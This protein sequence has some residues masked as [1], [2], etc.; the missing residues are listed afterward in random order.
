MSGDGQLVLNAAERVFAEFADA[1]RIAADAT[2][3]WKAPLWQALHDMGLPQAWAPEALSG[4]GLSLR[5]GFDVVRAAGRAAIAVPLVETLLAGWIAGL[6]GL[7]MPSGAA[8]V[9]LDGYGAQVTAAGQAMRMKARGV[10]FAGEVQ[11]LVVVADRAGGCHVAVV[12]AS[13]CEIVHEPNLAGD[14]SGTVSASLQ[15]DDWSDADV[16]FDQVLFVAAT[17]R[18]LQMAGA[19]EAMLPMGVQYA[20]ERLAFGKPIGSFQAVQQNLSRLAGETAAALAA[21]CSAADALAGGET[22]WEECLLEV[23]AAKVR[24]GE[25]VE[26]GAAVAHQVLGALGFTNEHALHRFTLRALAWRDDFGT[27]VHWARRLG[28]LVASQGG[29]RFWPLLSTR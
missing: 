18:S 17:C 8:T 6:A 27:E 9:V 1:Q 19:L 5:E 3:D 12:A 24:C 22:P 21:S 11:S 20:K 26:A 2:Y 14:P 15:Q 28:V 16:S 7:Q 25:A 29:A 4:S 23:A 13:Y 10:P